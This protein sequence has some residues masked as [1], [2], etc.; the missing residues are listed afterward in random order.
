MRQS[1]IDTILNLIDSALAT[2]SIDTT[3]T[4]TVIPLHRERTTGRSTHRSEPSF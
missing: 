1:K 2:Y 4:A 3:E